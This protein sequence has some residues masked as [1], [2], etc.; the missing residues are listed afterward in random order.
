MKVGKGM[1]DKKIID[2][3]E[4]ANK[5]FKHLLADVVI[6]SNNFVGEYF[7]YETK[8]L[9]DNSFCCQV[10]A[11]K[12]SVMYIGLKLDK[13]VNFNDAYKGVKQVVNTM[14]FFKETQAIN[15][16]KML[17]M[18]D[19]Y[20]KLINIIKESLTVLENPLCEILS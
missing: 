19:D 8:T 14:E 17:S 10:I 18:K 11:I 9:D 20:I 16:N 13:D 12:C 6:K 3:D 7:D 5:I 2:Y 15:T 1:I 4:G